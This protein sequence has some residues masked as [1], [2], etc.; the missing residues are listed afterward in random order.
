MA[1]SV[2]GGWESEQEPTCTQLKNAW[3]CHCFRTSFSHVEN[4]PGWDSLVLWNQRRCSQTCYPTERLLS[5]VLM[6]KYLHVAEK[7]YQF[8][9]NETCKHSLSFSPYFFLMPCRKGKPN[10]KT[11]SQKFSWNHDS[12]WKTCAYLVACYCMQIRGHESW[13]TTH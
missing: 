1:V 9:M 13:L 4:K 10:C 6:R 12:I 2:V 3:S 11:Y 7:S 8:T 5:V